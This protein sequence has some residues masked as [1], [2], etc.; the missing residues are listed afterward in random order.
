M[1]ILKLILRMVMMHIYIYN[2][3]LQITNF[4]ITKKIDKNIYIIKF[5]NNKAI[6]KHKFL[7]SKNYYYKYYINYYIMIL[8]EMIFI[9]KI[10]RENVIQYFAT[11]VDILCYLYN[12]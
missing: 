11:L 9:L 2:F 1:I 7:N 5:I 4:S 6:R 12:I 3:Q 10:S 8:K